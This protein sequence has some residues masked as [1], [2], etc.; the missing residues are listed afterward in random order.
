[1]RKHGGLRIAVWHPTVSGRLARCDRIAKMIED[2][3]DA[4]KV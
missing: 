4:G 3:L 1:M 2:M